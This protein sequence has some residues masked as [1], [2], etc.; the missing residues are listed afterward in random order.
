MSTL[1]V[2]ELFSGVQFNQ[3]IKISE[4]LNLAHVRPWIYKQGVLQ[5]GDFKLT[6]F[7]GGN[8]LI[9]SEISYVDINEA[10]PADFFHGY[11]RFDFKSAALRVPEKVSE[12]EYTFRFEMINHT[13]DTNNF[14]AIS[15]TWDQKIYPIYGEDVINNEPPNDS[16]EPGGVELYAWKHV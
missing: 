12:K 9:S 13:T 6:I 1:L 2:D 15:R 11:I 5:D 14:I 4:D 3:K 16:V 10:I 7:D 8:E